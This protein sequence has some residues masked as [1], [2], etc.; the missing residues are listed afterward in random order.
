MIWKTSAALRRPPDVRPPP[1]RLRLRDRLVS[2]DRP[3][4]YARHIR[5]IV[6]YPAGEAQRFPRA[7][8]RRRLSRVVSCLPAGPRPQD[9]RPLAVRAGPDNHEF[10]WKGGR[11][12]SFGSTLPAQT[13]KVAA[14]QA[15]FSTSRHAS[16]P[17]GLTRTSFTPKVADAPSANRR[18]GQPEAGN[19]A[20]IEAAVLPLAARVSAK[21]GSYHGQPRPAG[22]T[23][24]RAGA[25]R[26]AR[27]SRQ[28]CRRT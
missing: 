25:A 24:T 18:P 4:G 1:R 13:R 11:A 12:R 9:A 10:S 26:S 19:L 15:W 6:R 28:S 21:P 20:A 17:N 7:D 5:D 14:N 3:Q 16:M 2:Q 8:D 23:T 27:R 22:T